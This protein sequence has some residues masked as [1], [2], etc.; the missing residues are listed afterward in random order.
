MEG[1]SVS[2]TVTENAQT[3]VLPLASVAVQ[4]TMVVP[5]GKE[6]PLAGEQTEVTPGQL[7]VAV[8]M[9]V[10]L[11]AQVPGEVLTTILAGQII[12]GASASL[13]ATVKEQVPA[14]PQPSVAVQ[15]TLLV[16]TAKVE[17]L[18]GTQTTMEL[19]SQS[20]TLRA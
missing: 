17:P 11:L 1:G 6:E 7:S 4:V 8:A 20:V 2:L 19:G 16:P 13:M 15:R 12:T 5:L 10:T 18:V 3:L 14:L 9:K